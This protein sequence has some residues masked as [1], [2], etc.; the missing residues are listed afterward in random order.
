M[1]QESKKA[2]SDLVKTKLNNNQTQAI[3]L[4]VEHLGVNMFKNST[5]LKVLNKNEFDLVPQELARWIR[6]NGRVS[7]QMIE[8]RQIE[9][10][11]F[12]KQP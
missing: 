11:L 12:T 10:D 5:L 4:F 1:S 9:I 3:E 6:N 7:E 2:I 8:Q